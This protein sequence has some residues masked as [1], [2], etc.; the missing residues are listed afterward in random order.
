MQVIIVNADERVLLLS[1]LT[2]NRPGE[3]QVISGSLEAAVA[4]LAG[5]LRE[6]GEEAGAQLRVRPL[7]VVHAHTFHFD[8]QVR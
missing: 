1:S 5:V 2:R 3:W 8:A 6:V 4:V 7:G